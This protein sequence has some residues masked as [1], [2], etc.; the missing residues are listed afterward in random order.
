[1]N[2]MTRPVL[3]VEA[4]QFRQHHDGSPWPANG[5]IVHVDEVAEGWVRFS[6]P[7][8]QYFSDQRMKVS[9]FEDLYN[10]IVPEQRT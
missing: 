9:E 2:D 5:V 3:A 10:T 7:G 4:G 6:I 8:N 1:M